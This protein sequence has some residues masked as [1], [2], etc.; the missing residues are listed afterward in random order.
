MARSSSVKIS[1]PL[2]PP[3]V[4]LDAPL[5]HKLL[6]EL[7]HAQVAFDWCVH[8]YVPF[9]YLS[10]TYSLTNLVSCTC[11]MYRFIKIYIK[12]YVRP[13]NPSPVVV[14]GNDQPESTFHAEWLARKLIGLQRDRK[15]VALPAPVE[16]LTEPED[17]T[18]RTFNH[19][20]HFC[21]TIADRAQAIWILEGG[22]EAFHDEYSFLCGHIEFTEMYPLPHQI[23]RNLFLGTR[24]FPVKSQSLA[25]IRV[26][27]VIV[28][29]YQNLDWSELHGI[30]VLKCA[31]RDTNSQDMIPCWSA[32]TKFID[33]ATSVETNRVLVLLFGRSRSTSVILAHLMKA[34]RL[35][36][37]DAWEFV[38]SKCWHLIDRSL[39]YE[40]QLRA[41]ARTETGAIAGPHSET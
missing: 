8:A 18:D 36:F 39:V 38:C 13:E 15:S 19:F 37:E 20:E 17:D 29:E 12:E 2:V 26:T 27:H 28:S 22:Y 32:C 9:L 34:L 14:Y 33:E 31:V 11:N 7:I 16:S 5:R 25:D 21:L 30:T 10:L 24:V 1:R 40:D 41:W 3:P 6:G 23:T 35:S 4:V